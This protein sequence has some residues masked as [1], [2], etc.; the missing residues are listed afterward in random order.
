MTPLERIAAEPIRNDEYQKV[1]KQTRAQYVYAEDGVSNHGYR[2]GMLDMVASYKMYDT[3]LENLEKVK[4]Q[5]I[6]RVAAKYLAENNRTVGWFIPTAE[7]AEDGKG[8][9]RRAQAAS[10]KKK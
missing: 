1:L 7:T 5:D 6:Q 10:R 3:F 4:K 2:L 8:K 9:S